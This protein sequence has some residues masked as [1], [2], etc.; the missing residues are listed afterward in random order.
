MTTSDID[1]AST[2]KDCRLIRFVDHD[3]SGDESDDIV[4]AKFRYDLSM[5]QVRSIDEAAKS[6]PYNSDY[7]T[8]KHWIEHVIEEAKKDASWW[9]DTSNTWEFWSPDP[10]LTLEVFG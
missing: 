7:E 4:Y 1:Q 2:L 9:H 3:P 5:D 10:C 8:L 6:S